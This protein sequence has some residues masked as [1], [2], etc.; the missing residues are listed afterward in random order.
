MTNNPT[1]ENVNSGDDPFL[2][3][4]DAKVFA[5]LIPPKRRSRSKFEEVSGLIA[6]AQYS[7]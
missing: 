1:S 2:I 6:Y 7:L 5:I 3:K 4:E